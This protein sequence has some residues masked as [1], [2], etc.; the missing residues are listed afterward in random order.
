MLLYVQ[1][2]GSEMLLRRESAVYSM[3]IRLVSIGKYVD[4]PSPRITN[5]SH[6]WQAS[7]FYHL[8]SY[9]ACL[10]LPTTMLPQLRSRALD[11]LPN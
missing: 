4:D 1:G 3:P 10:P 7:H 8:A 9:L 2:K 6:I 5:K 11:E